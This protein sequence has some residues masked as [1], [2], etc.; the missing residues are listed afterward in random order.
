MV[1][2][3]MLLTFTRS[4]SS[5]QV[6]E[7]KDRRPVYV[8]LP[9]RNCTLGLLRLR[10]ASTVYFRAEQKKEHGLIIHNLSHKPPSNMPD[11][12]LTY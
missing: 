11:Y 3:E 5:W 1:L 8:F 2:Y 10:S 4:M 6:G 9:L 7:E 12:S